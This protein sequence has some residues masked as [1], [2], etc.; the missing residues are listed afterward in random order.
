[1]SYQIINNKEDWERFYWYADYNKKRGEPIPSPT[2]YPCLAKMESVEGGVGEDWIKYS[3][4]VAYPPDP[5]HTEGKT[6]I[7]LLKMF[8]DAKWKPIKET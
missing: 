1:M 3:H 7:E 4:Y 5:I 8:K 6:P 2:V